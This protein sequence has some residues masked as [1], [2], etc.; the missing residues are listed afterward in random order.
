M[1]ATVPIRVVAMD[2]SS[3]PNPAVPSPNPM[4]QLRENSGHL[5]ICLYEN[6]PLV[7]LGPA[8][9]FVVSDRVVAAA[10]SWLKTRTC[11]PVGDQP[12]HDGIG[13]FPGN[14]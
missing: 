5:G 10:G 11:N 4:T 12:I 1:R 14:L 6:N 7:A 13:S 2:G 9:T 3:I 8:G